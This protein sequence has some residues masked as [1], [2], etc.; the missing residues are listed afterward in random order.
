MNSRTAVELRDEIYGLINSIKFVVEKMDNTVKPDIQS[1]NDEQK[2]YIRTA[3]TTR[4]SLFKEIVDKLIAYV[5]ACSCDHLEFI[6][7]RK[8]RDLTP[9]QN[10][11]KIAQTG[12]W[13]SRFF[14]NSDVTSQ[15][16]EVKSKI[17]AAKDRFQ[18]SISLIY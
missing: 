6:K 5:V 16:D 18:V 2:S 17:A 8:C 7:R 11:V 1:L 10:D 14:C 15:L 9:L 4:P 3:Q 12:S 13:L